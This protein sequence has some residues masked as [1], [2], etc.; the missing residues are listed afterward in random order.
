MKNKIF[1]NFWEEKNGK[2]ILNY[3]KWLFSVG[4]VEVIA[5]VAMIFYL[6]TSNSGSSANIIPVVIFS[7][8]CILVSCY[9]VFLGEKIIH[10]HLSPGEILNNST[11][12]IVVV[13]IKFATLAII[14][15]LSGVNNIRFGL[16]DAC[17]FILLY[18]SIKYKRVWHNE[19]LVAFKKHH[20]K[21]ATSKSAHIKRKSLK[22]KKETPE[23]KI[24]AKKKK[25]IIFWSCLIC[26]VLIIGILP[27]LN[28]IVFYTEEIIEETIPS[29]TVYTTTSELELGQQRVKTT[30]YDG[31]ENVTYKVGKRLFSGEISREKI[32]SKTIIEATNTV[33]E[34]GTIRYRFMW[35]SDNYYLYYYEDDFNN[36]Q[37]IGYTWSG[38]DECAKQ[39]HG[40]RV[41]VQNY[42]PPSRY[43]YFY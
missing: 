21:K 42:A 23:E 4:I 8:G 1:T 24:K 27:F 41:N 22:L 25:S 28:N 15:I 33:I 40:A 9:F 26:F 36:N 18:D 3:G 29:Q 10:K 5:Y 32:G 20:S 43:Y 12:V 17:E 38:E 13:L 39:G 31:K 16:L 7:V 34:K 6:L 19:Y 14:L 11:F 2:V 35:C 37:N 30:G